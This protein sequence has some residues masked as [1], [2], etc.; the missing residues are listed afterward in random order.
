MPTKQKIFVINWDFSE[1]PELADIVQNVRAVLQVEVAGTAQL[2]S[3]T[4]QIALGN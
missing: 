3:L 2:C 4:S 1:C